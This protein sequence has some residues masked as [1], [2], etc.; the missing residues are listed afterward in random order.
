MLPPRRL[1]P[2]S[3]ATAT[4]ALA[5]SSAAHAATT[6]ATGN[7]SATV[8]TGAPSTVASTSGQG[9]RATTSTTAATSNTTPAGD[10]QPDADGVLSDHRYDHTTV[11]AS[12]MNALRQSVG[13]SRMPH[14]AMHTPQN[15]NVVPQVLM[16][17]YEL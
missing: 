13:L 2:F 16:Q 12:P 3:A 11:T 1:R 14:D 10:A 4:L 5:C 7:A 15:I 9:G 17:H 8:L 6:S